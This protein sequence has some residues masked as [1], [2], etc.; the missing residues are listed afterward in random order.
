METTYSV[1]EAKNMSF[2][3]YTTPE[4]KRVEVAL[5]RP[6][7]AIL[8]LLYSFLDKK[9]LNLIN[10]YLFWKKETN[11]KLDEMHFWV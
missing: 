1:K 7:N 2:I 9:M 11:R 5:L 3:Y 4:S 10:F 6:F 8:E